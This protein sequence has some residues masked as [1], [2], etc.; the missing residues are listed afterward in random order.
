SSEQAFG[1]KWDARL[2]YLRTEP[3]VVL[4]YLKLCFKTDELCFDYNGWP[5]AKE[6]RDWLPQT[7]VLGV[8][9][10]LT[11][12]GLLLRRWWGFAG[13]WFF[14]LLAPTSSI[15]PIPD[16]AFEHRMYLSLA[17]V[18]LLVVGAGYALVRRLAAL[19]GWT[20]RARAG[21]GVGLLLLAGGTL[22]A[23]T[24]LR[25][26]DYRTA[27]ALYVDTVRKNPLCGREWYNLSLEQSRADDLT[28]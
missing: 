20:E 14:L 4:H 17:G 24:V 9:G 27:E 13:A 1:A 16:V 12:A 25:N 26:E 19:C 28:P 6:R 2:R 5:M 7:I 10:L 11:L 18:V 3:G 22:T 21:V 15:V 23:L 8:L